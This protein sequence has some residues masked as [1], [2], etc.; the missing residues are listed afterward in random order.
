M[1]VKGI[2]NLN[3]AIRT[4]VMIVFSL[5]IITT[6]YSLFQW[7]FDSQRIE[8][9]IREINN[10]VIAKEIE[11]DEEDILIEPPKN[12]NDSYWEFAKMSMTDV[13]LTELKKLNEETKG[14]IQVPGTDV[15]YPF[16]QHKDNMFYLNHSFDQEENGAGWVF[17]DFR[18]DINILDRNNIIYAHGRINSVLFGT[19]KDT[20]KSDWYNNS[21]NHI[22][23]VSAES[24]NTLWQV[25]SVYHV[26]TTS[27]YIVTDFSN[28]TTY[29][30]FLNF[31]KERSIYD[32]NVDLDAQ[33][34][35]M[36]LST[37][38]SSKEKLVMHA[39]LIKIDVK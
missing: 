4:V 15:N 18:N 7:Y 38:Y 11:S 6:V 29:Q 17:M 2:K 3:K 16:V 5:G 37:C 9:Q 8:K 39:K 31:I 12:Q 34:K 35:I 26:P 23:K 24:H 20:V 10:I 22:I 27:D 13:D 28:D 21:D 30:N 19:L 25:F 36:T 14:W 33:D 1:R 32:F